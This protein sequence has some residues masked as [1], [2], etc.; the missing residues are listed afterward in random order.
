MLRKLQRT[1]TRSL[2][3]PA[4]SEVKNLYSQLRLVP[5]TLREANAFVEQFHRHHKP[6]RGH[7]FS[8]G[9]VV[10]DDQLVGAVIVGRP[11][12]RAVNWKEVAEVNRLV[13]DGTPHVCS[14]LYAAAARACRAMGYHKIHTYIL[15]SEPGTS[16]KAAGWHKEGDTVGGD[17]N[18]PGRKGP[19]RT[20][21]PMEPK[22]RWAKVLNP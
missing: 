20:D 9:A 8:I 16:L 11:V 2:E 12:A 14:M 19:R 17:W 6:S 3:T 1:L 10:G 22:Q 4:Q 15:Q 5:L 21:Q 18:C 7:K 13:T